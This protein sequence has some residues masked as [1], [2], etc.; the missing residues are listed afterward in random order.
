[1]TGRGPRTQPTRSPPQKSLLI[2]PTV[3]TLARGAKRA[4]G[5]GGSVP[6][7]SSASVSSSITGVP[8]SSL[9]QADLAAVA[10]RQH[11]AGGILVGRHQVDE[12]GL[13]RLDGVPQCSA[14]G[15]DRDRDEPRSRQREHVDR[16]EVGRV[17]EHDVCVARD[18][19]PRHE[20]DRLLRAG[21]DQ[22]LVRGRGHAAPL[23]VGR[24]RA[25][26]RRPA[27]R[28]EFAGARGYLGDVRLRRAPLLVERHARPR[29][30]GAH[31]ADRALRLERGGTRERVAE[32]GAVALVEA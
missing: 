31:E 7:L 21:G 15:A 9:R 29:Q 12:G 19:Q 6:K 10:L 16:A 2:E 27:L 25:A 14:R 24:D 28:R 32:E 13:R 30:A 4:I 5:G 23:E 3:R 11:A 18:Q 20:I 8:S 22:D 26:Q 1:M 17:L